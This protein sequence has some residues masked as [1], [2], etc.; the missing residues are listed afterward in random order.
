VVYCWGSNSTG[1]LG[2][3]TNTGP[4][5]CSTVGDAA[6]STRPV[7]VVGGLAFRQVSAGGSHSCGLT[8]SNVAY[9]WVDNEQGQLGIGS[10][11]GPETWAGQL[12]DGTGTGP[13]TCFG[14][15]CNPR[16]VQVVGGLAFRSVDLGVNH[17]CGLATSKAVYCWGDNAVGQLGAGTDI[18]PEECGV[19]CST[20]PVAVVPPARP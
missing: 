9:C 3:G 17:A 8:T 14:S 5:G 11:T 12:G 7:R 10:T 18:G 1:E 16:P 13:E 15:P 4:E 2:T 20:R 6:C 19:P